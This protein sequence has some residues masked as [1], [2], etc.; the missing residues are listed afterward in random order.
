MARIRSIKPEFWTNSTTGRLSG[1]A[2]KLYLGLHNH[3]D[4]YGV[5]RLN[6]D[7]FKVKILPYEKGNGRGVNRVLSEL[8]Q[9]GADENPHGL[10]VRFQVAAKA[11][12]WLPYFTKHQRVEKPGKPILDGWNAVTTPLSYA[13]SGNVPVTLLEDSGNIPARA[14]AEGEDRK[15]EERNGENARDE[16]RD[17]YEKWNQQEGLVHHNQFRPAMMTAATRALKANSEQDIEMA[18]ELYA[19]VLG[20]NRHYWTQRWTLDEFLTRGLDRFLPDTQPLVRFLN[21][22]KDQ[23]QRASEVSGPARPPVSELPPMPDRNPNQ[24]AAHA[25]KISERLHHVDL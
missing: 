2:T 6:P 20:S 18:V 12:L 13:D 23:Q 3:A 1:P 16:A 15:G 9:A 14:R 10:I 11:Y 21:R 19:I 24:L 25:R 5:V 4:D 8:E 7:E 22:D 17:I